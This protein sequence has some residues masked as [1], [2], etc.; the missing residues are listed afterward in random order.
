MWSAGCLPR[1]ITVDIHNCFR[2]RVRCFL[3]QV[4]SDAPFY[5][6]VRI[7]SQEFFGIGT[8]IRVWRTIG[9]TFKR[10]RGHG[11]DWKCRKPLFQ[12]VIFRL[13]FSHA[14]PPAVVVNHDADVIRIVEGRGTAIERGVLELPFGRRDLPDELRKGVPVLVVADAAA[15]SGE[16]ELIPSLELGCRGQRHLARFLAA[17]QV[18]AHG[19]H[20]L[21]SRRPERRDNIGGPRPPITPGEDR[22]LDVQRIHQG[23]DID[24][25]HRLLAVPGR[26][27]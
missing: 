19:H 15:L 25:E 6:P 1:L 10:N 13:A 9:I 23:D 20:G 7:L 16:I 22:P 18:A 3:R 11:D 24:G 26:R 8:G 4:V 17:D 14:Q 5:E 2:K 12:I 21:D 27:V